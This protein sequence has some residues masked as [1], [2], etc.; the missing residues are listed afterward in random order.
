MDTTKE[1]AIATL[2]GGCF[3][4]VE[5]IFKQLKGVDSVV[6]GYMGGK[7]KNPTYEEVCTGKT[8]HAEVVQIKF[9]AAIIKFEKLLEIFFKTHDPTTL[10]RQGND[11]GTQYRSAIFYHDQN[12][13]LVSQK[14]IKALNDSKAYSSAIVTTLEPASVFYRAEDYH[15]NYFEKNAD[16]NPYCAIVVQPKVDKFKKAFASFLK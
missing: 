6:S 10:N 8:G 16:K 5:A 11:V 9:D 15:Q 7:V 12:Q 4:C 2:A 3:W 14:I 1:P 13:K